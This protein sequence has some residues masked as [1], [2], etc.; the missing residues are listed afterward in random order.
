MD[1]EGLLLRLANIDVS[2]SPD[3]A[4]IGEGVGLYEEAEQDREETQYDMPLKMR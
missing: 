4:A 2:A 1:D 3:E